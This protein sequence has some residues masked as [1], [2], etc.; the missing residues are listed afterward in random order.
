MSD[1]QMA[2]TNKFDHHFLMVSKTSTKFTIG[3]NFGSIV[4]SWQ[5]LWVPEN[6]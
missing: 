1:Q 2:T 6:L 4:Y 3:K 5:I